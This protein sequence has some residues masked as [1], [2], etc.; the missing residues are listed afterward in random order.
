MESVFIFRDNSCSGVYDHHTIHISPTGAAVVIDD[1]RFLTNSLPLKY[2]RQ[3][4]SLLEFRNRFVQPYIPE[5]LFKEESRLITTNRIEY[6]RWDTKVITANIIV[7]IDKL[8]T[9]KFDDVKQMFTATFPYQLHLIEND[10]RFHYINASQTF[11]VFDVPKYWEYPA[12]MLLGESVASVAVVARS[13]L[14]VTTA[15]QIFD[16]CLVSAS[17]SLNSGFRPNSI[18]LLHFA[19]MNEIVVFRNTVG[20]FMV[21][22]GGELFIELEDAVL[23]S[24]GE[25]SYF[26]MYN[27]ENTQEVY[28]TDSV[29]QWLTNHA[30]GKEYPMQKI[31][32]V[33][34]S[35][36]QNHVSYSFNKNKEN[37]TVGTATTIKEEVNVP[38]IGLFTMYQNGNATG[39]FIDGTII[40]IPKEITDVTAAEVT[41]SNGIHFQLRVMKPIGYE[42]KTRQ[43][44]DFQKWLELDPQTRKRIAIQKEYEKKYYSEL[45]NRS[46]RTVPFGESTSELLLT[47][48]K[49]NAEFLQQ[50][51][52]PL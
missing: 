28:R 29:F 34:L 19:G 1:T 39:K 52:N 9:L 7:S 32:S 18:N 30:S 13:E 50:T 2:H 49:R 44:L 15:I 11:T 37:S 43:L 35:M 12:T 16:P 40:H 41:D 38:E 14:H 31:L 6:A 21:F 46:K 47:I 4:K 24:D 51:R 17:N 25:Y 22:K 23:I 36:Y 45:I 48:Q 42:E 20:L 8:F 10:K 3:V 33:G 26:T 27:R 5:I